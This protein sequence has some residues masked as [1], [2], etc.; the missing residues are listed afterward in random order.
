MLGGGLLLG[1]LFQALDVLI[2]RELY[3]RFD[4]ALTAR[5]RLL[6][7]ELTGTVPPGVR[8]TGGWPEF[9]AGNHTDFFQL[10]GSDGT[11]LARS[12]SSEGRDLA[13]PPRPPQIAPVLYDLVL[14][15]GHRGRAAALRI[16][17]DGQVFVV[18]A[19]RETLDTLEGRIHAAL[20]VA[21]GVVLLLLVGLSFMAVRRALKPLADFGREAERRSREPATTPYDLD[22][23]PSEL[24]PIAA[25]LDRALTRLTRMLLRERRFARD[26][27]HELRTPLAEMFALVETPPAGHDEA[28]RR[29]AIARSLTGMTRIVDGLL[30]LARYEAGT[31]RPAIEPVDLVAVMRAQVETLRGDADARGLTLATLLPTEAWVMSDELL[32][33]RI[34]ANLLGNA[35]AHAPAG[36]GVTVRCVREVTGPR[37]SIENDAPDLS[38]TDVARLGERHFRAAQ[39]SASSGHAGLGLALCAALAEQLDLTIGYELSGARLRVELSGLR[40]LDAVL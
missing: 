40:H 36:S 25:A 32:L 5:S 7:S 15:D 11:T 18:A 2:E 9:R 38:A 33:E 1:L 8:V 20:I 13:P 19:E 34:V 31:D 4:A 23:L 17:R 30:A 39:A 28:E 6:A 26:L 24:R 10:W 12:P 29:A 37:L 3:T 22:A 16:D 35:I 14:P 21:I 27:A